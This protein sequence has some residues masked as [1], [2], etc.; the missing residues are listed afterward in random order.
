V[1]TALT[2]PRLDVVVALIRDSAGRVLVSQRLP[3]RPMAGYW[4]FPGGKRTPGE[5]RREA[6]A[7]ELGE[8]LG[9]RPLAAA[10]FMQLE[11]DY[12][13]TRVALDI[14]VVSHYAGEPRALEG[15][16]LA[17]HAPADLMRIE[18]LPADRP[19]V[20]RLLGGG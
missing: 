17:W 4:E 19:I 3:D 2:A 20:V 7:R 8:E 14:W 11:H 6:L 10:P 5:G 13:D 9:I 15:Q 12:P 1:S 18:L 16:P